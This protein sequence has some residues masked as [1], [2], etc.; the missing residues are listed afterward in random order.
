MEEQI[1]VLGAPTAIQPRLIDTFGSVCEFSQFEENNK[2]IT[3]N[4]NY[5]H[6]HNHNNNNHCDC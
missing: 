2:A 5:N 1:V 6:H 4:N 3:N